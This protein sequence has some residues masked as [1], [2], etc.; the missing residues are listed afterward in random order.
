MANSH[1]PVGG[2]GLIS[3]IAFAIKTLRPEVK[4]YGIAGVDLSYSRENKHNDHG[5]GAHPG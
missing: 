1:M 2:G 5:F 3:G 4:V